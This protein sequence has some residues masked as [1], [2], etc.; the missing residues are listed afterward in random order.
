M[1]A[2][3]RDFRK[4]KISTLEAN[5]SNWGA[6]KHRIT[7]TLTVNGLK[8]IVNGTEARPADGDATLANWITCDF[9]AMAQIEFTIQ[10]DP[11][12]TIMDA[13]SAKDAWDR[14]C[15]QYEGKGKKCLV[16]LID[17]VF[18][19]KFTDT[20]PLETQMNDMLAN[21]RNINELK[22][23]LT[24]RSQQSCSS[25]PYPAVSTLCK[26]YSATRQPLPLPISIVL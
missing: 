19:T 2:R 1:A 4:Y 21:I 26:P 12:Q 11:L 6:W 15:D 22:P 7:R 14:L 24:T 8:K 13:N 18:H 17:K 25:T 3:D 16:Q 9:E 10:D 5:R 23:T 20:K